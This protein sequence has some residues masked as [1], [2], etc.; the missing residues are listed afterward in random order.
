[1]TKLATAVTKLNPTTLLKVASQGP[2]LGPI[3][4]ATQNLAPRYAPVVGVASNIATALAPGG[5][6]KMA[7]NLG[8]ILNQVS[9]IFGGSQNP[10][11]QGISDISS[12]ASQFIPQPT[13]QPVAA[14]VPQIVG[15]MV[16]SMPTVGRGFFNKYPNLAVA[17][18]NL[19]NQGRNIKRSQLWS[20]LKRFGPEMLITGGILT[21]A[22][23]SELIQ[24][25]P[26]RRT[27]NPANA[28][29][30]RRAA[31]RIKGFHKL[32][33]HTDLIKSRSR[34][35]VGRCGTC[36]KSPCRC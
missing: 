12:L 6:P 31:R 11:F 9:G 4:F 7:I 32:C 29:A 34:R 3:N 17:M 30:L 5:A 1:V 13:A 36:R 26:G 8:G 35:S 15:P 10:V 24:A 27:M 23:V 33:M 2:V 18:Q 20:M 21:A 16:R 25:G 28:K 22:A 19:R 14:R